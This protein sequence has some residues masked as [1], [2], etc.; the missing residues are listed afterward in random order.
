MYDAL[1]HFLTSAAHKL[2]RQQS[3]ASLLQVFIM[4]DRFRTE[5]PQYC[6]CVSIPLPLP[7]DNTITLQRY[8]STAL[9]AVYRPGYAYKRA[10]LILGGI[11]PNDR[12]QADFFATDPDNPALMIAL[13]KINARY[14][15]GTLKLSHDGSTRCWATKQEKKSPEYTTSWNEIPICT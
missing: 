14:G 6:P 12:K 11:I 9:E 4:T 1:A 10:G 8:V 2:R 13:D 3:C 5:Q 15:K 7:T